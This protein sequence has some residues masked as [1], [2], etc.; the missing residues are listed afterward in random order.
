MACSIVECDV[1]YI[2]ADFRPPLTKQLQLGSAADYVWVFHDQSSAPHYLV[3]EERERPIEDVMVAER[4]LRLRA[5]RFVIVLIREP[6][7]HVLGCPLRADFFFDLESVDLRVA[8][9]GMDFEPMAVRVYVLSHAGR[10]QH[11][12]AVA[13]RM[14][15]ASRPHPRCADVIEV[16]E[17][18]RPR[19]HVA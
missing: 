2:I 8:D 5:M 16:E 17:V 11:E 1:A 10:E 18:V 9:I 6:D 3:M 14:P 15:L 19:V 12:T 7:C 13:D 4:G